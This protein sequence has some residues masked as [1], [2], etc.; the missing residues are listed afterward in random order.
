MNQPRWDEDTRGAGA[1]S[2]EAFAPAAQRLVEALHEP[3][4]VAEQPEAHLLPHLRAACEREGSPWR[5][6]STELDGVAYVVTLEWLRTGRNLRQ[7]T[8]DFYS[9]LG[10]IAESNTHV[11]ELTEP[12]VIGFDVATGMLAGDGRFAA[13]GHTLRFRIGGEAVES[14]LRRRG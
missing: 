6:G 14:I 2:G 11:R 4:W 8:V 9:L 10:V 3:A 7:L 5:L 12:G 13:H 1:G